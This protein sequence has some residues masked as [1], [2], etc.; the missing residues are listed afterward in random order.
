M[1][2]IFAAP[3]QEYTEAAFR[4]AHSR[5]IGGIDEYYTPFIRL[6]G[7]RIPRRAE[8]DI[9]PA[10]NRCA[11]VVPQILVKNAD[12]TRRLMEHL[13]ELGYRRVDFNF[14]CPFTKVVKSG[15]GAGILNKP[16]AI[17]ET[18]EAA[19]TFKDFGVSV[20]MRIGVTE[21]N[22]ALALLDV[23]ND[24]PLTHIVLHPRTAVQQ[25]AGEPDRNAFRNFQ[26]R[27]RHTVVFNGDIRQAGDADGLDN[28]MIGRALLANPL[29][30]WELRHENVDYARLHAFH[31]AYV[32][33][34]TR[35]YEQPL[36]KLKLF[37]EYFLPQADKR[38]RKGIKKSTSL[39]EY[40][41]YSERILSFAIY[42]K[43]SVITESLLQ[44]VKIKKESCNKWQK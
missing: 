34:C 26:E 8:T 2:K 19:L 38:L 44:E 23:L 33:E 10:N 30:P 15:Y 3:I 32:E 1:D 6:E 43:S 28:V 9:A 37:W 22:A 40:L 5:V 13:G 12:E 7:E 16:D 27:C 42:I 29:L 11:N 36:L 21:G 35:I 17:R 39:S 41:D 20:K 4:N 14:G 25:Y 24:I 18:L 31:A